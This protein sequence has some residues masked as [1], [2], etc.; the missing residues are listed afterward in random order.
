MAAGY[1]VAPMWDRRHFL[2]AYLLGFGSLQD[3]L[4][5]ARSQSIQISKNF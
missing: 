5:E 1:T 4:P 3:S 2:R